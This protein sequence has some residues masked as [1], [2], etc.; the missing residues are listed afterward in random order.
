MSIIGISG[1]IGSGKDTVA[2][3]ISELTP[4]IFWENRKFADKLKDIVCILLGCTKEQ[5][6]DRVFK[7]STLGEEWALLRETSSYGAPDVI[8]P[9]GY[10][11]M[12]HMAHTHKEVLTPRRILQLLGTEGGRKII[13]P[14]IWVNAL[15]GE[16]SHKDD[17]LITD[18]RF[19]NELEAVKSKGGVTIRIERTVDFDPDNPSK[20][21]STHDSETALDNAEFDFI[22][23]NTGTLEDLKEK[24]S[25]IL[26]TLS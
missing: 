7:E 10:K 17:W 23:Y 22:L 11:G 9:I 19:P 21:S 5:L 1:K 14:N 16:Y 12:M 26:K 24:V 6:E 15:M 2:E 13:H 18:M 4:H 20:Q 8:H 25:L 3:M